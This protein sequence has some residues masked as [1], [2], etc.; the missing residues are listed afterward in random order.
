MA[1][2]ALRKKE[3]EVA[4]LLFLHPSPRCCLSVDFHSAGSLAQV[5]HGQSNMQPHVQS[6]PGP[7]QAIVFYG[8]QATLIAIHF[9]R[10]GLNPSVS[11]SERTRK[12]PAKV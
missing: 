7:Y 11:Q 5:T 9:M 8:A 12:L 6:L 1:L 10:S 3:G 2:G 4:W